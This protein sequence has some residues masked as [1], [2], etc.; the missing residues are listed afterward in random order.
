MAVK[1]HG[2]PIHTAMRMLLE[3]IM[4]SVKE[5]RLQGLHIV[6]FHLSENFRTG[7]FIETGGRSVVAGSWGLGWRQSDGLDM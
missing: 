2:P 6:L 5:T 1:R 4:L 3:G 7:E